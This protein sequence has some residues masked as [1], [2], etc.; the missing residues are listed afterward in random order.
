[1]AWARRPLT[2]SSSG[3]SEGKGRPRP[4]ELA[5]SPSGR[6]AEAGKPASSFEN[7]GVNDW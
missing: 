5:D 3:A 1:M 4:E 2:I 7:S 6:S